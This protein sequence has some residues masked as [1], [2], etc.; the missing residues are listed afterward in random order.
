[1]SV[2]RATREQLLVH[3]SEASRKAGHHPEHA[4]AIY[5]AHRKQATRREL[6][7]AIARINLE[8][9]KEK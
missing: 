9:P 8:T 7:E 5:A 2:N 6:R 3:L 1:M 4:A